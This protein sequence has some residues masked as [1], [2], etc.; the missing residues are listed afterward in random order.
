MPAPAP[1]VRR[2]C[3]QPPPPPPPR[4]LLPG[5]VQLSRPQQR[6]PPGCPPAG[7]PCPAFPSRVAPAAC[8]G[9]QFTRF[10]GKLGNSCR[11]GSSPHAN[12]LRPHP[13]RLQAAQLG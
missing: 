6:L 4:R 11:L 7:P 8:S 10:G 9:E 2:E 13:G 3:G 12:S 5:R 1:D